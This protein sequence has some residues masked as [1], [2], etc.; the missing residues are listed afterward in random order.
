[1]SE[2][3]DYYRWLIENSSDIISVFKLDG[4]ILYRSPAVERLLSYSPEELIGR[5]EF[6]YIHPDDH[7]LVFAAL[8]DVSDHRETGTVINYR[9]RH[10]DG[11]W[12]YLE[13]IGQ[14]VIDESGEVVCIVNSRDITGRK[15]AEMDRDGY[16]TKLRE[17]RSTQRAGDR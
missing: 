4:T 9:V 12:R 10:K 2:S 15:L 5:N 1:M 3:E 17:G 7:R 13:S 14:T 16:V 8:D 11:S 6:E